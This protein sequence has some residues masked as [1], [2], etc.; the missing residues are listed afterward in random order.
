MVL[1]A[2]GDGEHGGG[3]AVRAGEVFVAHLE[4]SAEG[5]GEG[6][7]LLGELLSERHHERGEDAVKS[8]KLGEEVKLR[9][10]G[11]VQEVHG[12]ERGD[13]DARLDDD[14]EVDELSRAPDGLEE[15][16]E[17]HHPDG[18]HRE[19]EDVHLVEA[20][21]EDVPHARDGLLRHER[22]VGGEEGEDEVDE[23]GHHEDERDRFRRGGARL[24]ERAELLLHDGQ[25]A[26]DLLHRAV[27][28]TPGGRRGRV[29]RARRRRRLDGDRGRHITRSVG[30]V[31]RWFASTVS[32]RGADST[33]RA[34][35]QQ[36]D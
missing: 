33:P 6:N 23:V 12:D 26:V 30:R 36:R 27:G 5:R 29:R 21:R 20:R 32:P 25:R 3:D 31:T 16:A 15:S 17:V 2:A 11:D 8:R 10:G 9:R 24:D 4:E 19:A 28:T 1:G 18:V 14:D 13:A 22:E 7:A 34:R 35:S